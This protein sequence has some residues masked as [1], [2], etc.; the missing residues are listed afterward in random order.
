VAYF[1]PS[2]GRKITAQYHAFHKTI[3]SNN[4][5]IPYVAGLKE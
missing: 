1:S 4:S 3:K 2:F 5:I